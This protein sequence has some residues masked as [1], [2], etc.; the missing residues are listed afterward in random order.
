MGVTA[1]LIC[2]PAEVYDEVKAEETFYPPNGRAMQHCFLDR[3]WD[4]LHLALR[5]FGPPLSLALSG[6]Y[7]YEGGLD[8]FGWDE[9]SERDHYLGFVSPSLVAQIAER[10]HGMTFEQLAAKLKGAEPRCRLS[11][12]AIPAASR[13]LCRGCGRRELRVHSC[14]VTGAAGTP[15]NHKAF[16]VKK[17]QGMRN[18]LRS[19]K[20]FLA[21]FTDHRAVE[22]CINTLTFWEN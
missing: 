10:L 7:G 14:G 13:V 22:Y 3:S 2:Y 12:P 16:S 8:L 6:D 5:S 17:N 9:A 15:N 1:G 18:Q 4:E 11:G 20:A 19:K 21:P